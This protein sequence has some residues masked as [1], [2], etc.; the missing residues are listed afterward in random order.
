[1]RAPQLGSF[2]R[3]SDTLR[4]LSVSDVGSSFQ[5]RC[6]DIIDSLSLKKKNS[7]TLNVG[8]VTSAAELQIP[9]DVS[10]GG[11]LTN[12]EKMFLTEQI[13]CLVQQEMTKSIQTSIKQQMKDLA[14]CTIWNFIQLLQI[15]FKV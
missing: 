5:P 13:K 2:A 4:H 8:T 10:V 9:F 12:N 7:P 11:I 14:S 3:H 15:L 1:M 6:N